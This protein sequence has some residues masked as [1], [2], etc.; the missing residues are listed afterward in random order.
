MV[1]GCVDS[2]GY[3]GHANTGAAD[4]YVWGAQS[5]VPVWD[6]HE[7]YLNL[8]TSYVPTSGATANRTDENATLSPGVTLTQTDGRFSMVSYASSISKDNQR[9]VQLETY[10]PLTYSTV[11]QWNL[12]DFGQT[13]CF[14]Q[15][16]GG[17][18]VYAYTTQSGSYLTATKFRCQS[19]GSVV[20]GTLGASVMTNSSGTLNASSATNVSLMRHQVRPGD[21]PWYQTGLISR[22]C[23]DPDPTVCQ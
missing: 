20:S 8:P 22:V 5:E 15:N 3:T 17:S 13:T 9:H 16:S 1:I 21:G 2:A 12:A 11:T 4:F 10:D 14:Q 6:A 19:N 7:W 18:Y 23:I